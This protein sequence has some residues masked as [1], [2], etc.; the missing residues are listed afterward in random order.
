MRQEPIREPKQLPLT[1]R[2]RFAALEIRRKPY[3]ISDVIP[4]LNQA[5]DALYQRAIPAQTSQDKPDLCGHDPFA[6]LSGEAQARA[7]LL[8]SQQATPE[9]SHPDDLAVDRFAAAMKSK[10]AASRAKGRGGWDDPE[11]CTVEHLAR[12]LVEHIPKGDPVDVANFAMMLHQRGADHSVLAAAAPEPVG[13]VSA[14][15]ILNQWMTECGIYLVEKMGHQWASQTK[16][17]DLL[18]LVEKA[19]SYTR[20]AAAPEP[21]QFNHAGYFY[22]L[23][24]HALMD[25]RRPE[26]CGH[27][28]RL[29]LDELAELMAQPAAPVETE[30]E[31]VATPLSDELERTRIE[32]KQERTPAYGDALALCRRLER[33]RNLTRP[34]K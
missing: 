16:H 4:L 24:A 26:A 7:Y 13:E 32:L 28:L 9:L 20:P 6:V 2:L 12:L 19:I 14:E 30:P 10:L 3:P 33:E 8:A 5:A 18:Y 21:V 1:D 23:V 22:N 15:S 27:R 17:A 29:I 34:T 31:E 25:V 11:Q